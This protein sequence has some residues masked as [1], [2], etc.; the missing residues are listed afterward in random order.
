MYKLPQPDPRTAAAIEFAREVWAFYVETGIE[1][2][3]LFIT[4]GLAV[5]RPATHEDIVLLGLVGVASVGD[6]VLGLTD[7]GRAVLINDTDDDRAASISS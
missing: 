1:I 4:C 6:E 2:E 7:L 5:L 3:Q